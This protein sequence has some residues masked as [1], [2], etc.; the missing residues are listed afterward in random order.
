MKTHPLLRMRRPLQICPPSLPPREH[1]VQS[2]GHRDHGEEED[3]LT[4]KNKKR[5]HRDHGEEE[6]T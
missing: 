4:K 5:C 1:F 2:R 6:E 3:T